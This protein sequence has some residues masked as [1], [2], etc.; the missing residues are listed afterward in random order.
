MIIN[1]ITVKNSVVWFLTEFE[2]VKNHTARF[3]NLFVF[4]VPPPPPHL[5]Y[6]LAFSQFCAIWPMNKVFLYFVGPG[7]GDKG[8]TL[9]PIILLHFQK[10]TTKGIILSPHSLDVYI[11]AG[12]WT[13]KSRVLFVLCLYFCNKLSKRFSYNKF[14][15]WI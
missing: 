1:N 8:N 5:P 3:L 7:E 9:S 14:H 11:V 13:E 4:S 15:V 12:H 10:G 2:L 6:T